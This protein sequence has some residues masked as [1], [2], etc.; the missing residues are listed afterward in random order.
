MAETAGRVR[1]VAMAMAVASGL[2][3]GRAEWRDAAERLYAA[4][5]P[6]RTEGYRM[7]SGRNNDFGMFHD[8][9]LARFRV[10]FDTGAAYLVAAACTSGCSRLA[11]EVDAPNGAPVA[12]ETADGATPQ[13]RL[14]VPE[15]GP[16]VIVVRYDACATRRC[17]WV[18]QVFR[19]VERPA[20]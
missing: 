17:R 7:L 12:S 1:A 8:S 13:I 6:A 10:W 18:A 9:G 11:L 19:R 4:T 16:H 5:A 3:C 2:G 20:P 14:S 15:A